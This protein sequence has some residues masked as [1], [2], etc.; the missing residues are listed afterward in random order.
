MRGGVVV[1]SI[2]RVRSPLENRTGAANGLFAPLR[3][4]RILNQCFGFS[5]HL[6]QGF[7]GRA[8]LPTCH[9]SVG[10]R[11]SESIDARK[12]RTW[13][14][15]GWAKIAVLVRSPVFQQT[16]RR[17]VVVAL[18]LGSGCGAGGVYHRVR[19]GETLSVIGKAYGVSYRS[20]A[21]VNDLDD[22]SRIFAGQ[23]LLIPGADEVIDWP[24]AP[25]PS[26]RSAARR[27]TSRRRP[28]D[29]PSLVWPLRGGVVT[30]V[31]GPRGK[32]F[33]DGIDIAAAVGVAVHA[34]AGGEVIY[35]GRLR[36]YGRVIILRHSSGYSTV[37]AHNSRHFVGKG[38]WVRRG[39][40]IAGVGKT[41]RATGPNLHFE[42]RYD[43]VARDPMLFLA[44]NS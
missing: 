24:L 30:S 14:N 4:W 33:H 31:F 19:P 32:R 39:Q 7:G 17:L 29:A 22:P 26:R 35:D 20:I 1:W 15:S 42:V 18:L 21:H 28:P 40:R 2:G 27:S 36:G 41:G 38:Q 3:R 10:D 6:R 8:G 25:A 37:Y 5:S 12:G 34:A 11:Q 44:P 16:V 23:K 43:N 9:W 13:P